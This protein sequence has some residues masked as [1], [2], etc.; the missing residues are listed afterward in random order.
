[1]SR[2]YAA[3]QLLRLEPIRLHEFVEATGWKYRA[4]QKVLSQLQ[5]RGQA[6]Q[7]KPGLWTAA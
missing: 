1:M 5:T 7:L 2:S 6:K 4:C 3:V